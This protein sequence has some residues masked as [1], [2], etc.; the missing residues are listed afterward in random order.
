MLQRNNLDPVNYNVHSLR[1]GRVSDLLKNQ[2]ISIGVL[3]KIGRWKSNIVYSY[4]MD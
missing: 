3:K 1:I 2:K 4:L